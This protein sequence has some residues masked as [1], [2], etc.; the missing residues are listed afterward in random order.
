MVSRRIHALFCASAA[1]ALFAASDAL[2]QSD[3]AASVGEIVVTAQRRSENI[4]NVPMAVTVVTPQILQNGGVQTFMDLGR[5]TAGLQMNYGGGVPGVALHGISTLVSSYSQESNVAAYVDGF[6]QPQMV[7]LASDVA[8][9][10]SIEVLKGPQGTLYGRNA[11]GGAILINTLGPTKTMTGKIDFSYASFNDKAVNAYLAGP[12]NDRVRFSVSAHGRLGDGWIRLIN[13]NVVG[14]Y[15]DP[16]APIKE[17]SLRFKL[18]A[19]LTSNLTAL[20]AMNYGYTEN[21][22]ANLLTYVDHVSPSLPK[23]PLRPVGFDAGAAYNRAERLTGENYEPTLTL[24]YKTPIGTLR[25]YTGYSSR[26]VQNEFDTD[27]SYV[28]LTYGTVKY[29][30]ETFQQTLDYH[31]DAIKNLDLV[32]GGTYYDDRIK[33]KPALYI[34][35]ANFVPSTIVYTGQ[36]TRSWALYFDGTYHATDQLSFDVGGRLS[37]DYREANAV[38]TT[39]KGVVIP[40]L[41]PVDDNKTWVKFTPRVSVRYELAAR[42]NV[43]ATFSQGF[44]SGI[45]NASGPTLGVPYKPLNPETINAYEIGFKTAKGVFTFNS[46]MFY[47]DYKD[48]Q[49]SVTVPNPNC[50]PTPTAPCGVANVLQNA[51][52]AT[53]YGW[54]NEFT[55]Q[56]VERLTVRGGLALLHARYKDFTNATGTGLNGATGL[57]INPQ[58]QDWTGV[59][60]PRA[61]TV[62]GNLSFDYEIPISYGQLL[63]GSA[64]NFTSSYAVSNPSIYGPLAPAGLQDKQRYTQSSYALFNAQIT[65]TAPDTH[66]Y[67]TVFGSNLS[68][69]L[70][71]LSYNGTALG[72]YSTVAQPRSV[73]VRVGASF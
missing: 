72:D 48:L 7:T 24:T 11:T 70:Y 66:Y 32:V 2:A 43:Y 19:D 10:S 23:P 57:N 58:V 22:S 68:N 29:D 69:T 41:G 42:T 64:V 13:P 63:L 40:G 26:I 54:D 21:Y 33:S 52:G 20:V 6:Y 27:G 73:G 56:P 44:R 39:G 55:L 28:D 4:V 15:G 34:T 1:V 35:G 17:A 61:P 12:I 71:R 46:S 5:V 60:L 51:P 16:A 3:P 30:E 65:W 18:E 9:I 50:T 45:Y 38:I 67:V 36:K 8:N 59:R 53:I 37:H 47:Y 62:A 14:E 49:V 31:I 25:S